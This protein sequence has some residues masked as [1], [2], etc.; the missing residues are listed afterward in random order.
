MF[1]CDTTKGGA[2]GDNEFGSTANPVP[3]HTA[4]T[5]AERLPDTAAHRRM[6]RVTPVEAAAEPP[7]AIHR[8]SVEASEEE[9]AGGV[10]RCETA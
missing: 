5:S 3:V 4:R 6:H 10:T 1:F 8:I 9:W 2:Q 7:S